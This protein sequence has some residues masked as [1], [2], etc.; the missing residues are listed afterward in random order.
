M[1]ESTYPA[2][3][4]QLL[5]EGTCKNKWP[6]YLEKLGLTA[7]YI[8]ALIHMATDLTLHWADSDSPAVWAPLHALRSLGQLKAEAAIDPLLE[9]VDELEDSDWFNDDLTKVFALIGP[10]AIPSLQ[11]FLADPTHLFYSRVTVASCLGKIGEAHPEARETCVAVLTQ[12]LEQFQKNAPAL[13]GFLLAYLLDLKAIESI[14]TIER[15]FTAKR[16]D[17]TIAGD[18]LDV[19]V[20]LG[21]KTHAEINRIRA[22]VDAEHLGTIAAKPVSQSPRGFGTAKPFFTKK[23]KK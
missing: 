19:Q 18:W 22:T 16:I 13:N 17:P 7:E 2:P 8:P 21:L 1:T 12:Q 10:V 23:P 20:A 6:N 9:M 5:T 14:P 3:L 15:A 4:D 11:N